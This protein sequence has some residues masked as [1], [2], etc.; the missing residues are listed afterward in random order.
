MRAI[1]ARERDPAIRCP[2]SLAQRLVQDLPA[3]RLVRYRLG[4]T[5]ARWFTE[6][7]AP[8]A[9]WYEIARVKHFD[10]LLLNALEDEIEQIVILGAGLDSRVHRFQ[11]QLAATVVYEV[12]H[13]VTSARKQARVREVLQE[14]TNVSYVPTDLALDD[15]AHK[16]AAA[17]LSSGRPVFVLCSGVTMYLNHDALNKL[18]AWMAARPS[19]SSIAFDYDY[20]SFISGDDSFH[21]AAKTRQRLADMGEPLTLGLDPHQLNEYLRSRQ[22]TL[23]SNLMPEQLT[24]R[25]LR[26]TKGSIAGIPFGFSAIAHARVR[27]LPG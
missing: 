16:L 12:D 10:A 25:Y 1:G 22:L 19:G 18:L 2:D 3:G 13:P 15:L 27:S 24:D 8:G 6:R 14:P 17:G 21:G 11:R 9:Y 5:V 7:R 20:E 4:C 23:I 26:S